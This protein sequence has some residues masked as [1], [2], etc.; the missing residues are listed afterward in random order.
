MALTL[1]QPAL[2]TGLAILAGTRL[3]PRVGLGAPLIEALLGRDGTGRVLRWQ[4]PAAAAGGAFAAAVL[5]GYARLVGA[6]PG[7]AGVMVPPLVT[8]LLYG[9]VVEELMMRWGLMSAAV[10]AFWKLS[11]SA[12]PP[13]SA[14]WGGVLAAALLFA[15]GHLPILLLAGGAD[16]GLI[17]AV[18]IGNAAPGIVFGWLYWRRGIEAAMLAHGLAHLIG[19]AAGH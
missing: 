5:I 18:L 3:G 10:W 8:R 11:R 13:V 4:L 15:L 17:A 16:P 14:Y 6:A 19:W 9:G 12:E 7:A 1:V 2:L